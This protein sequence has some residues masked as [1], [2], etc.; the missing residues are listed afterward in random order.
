MNQKMLLLMLSLAFAAFPQQD[1]IME[2]TDTTEAKVVVPGPAAPAVVTS[3]ASRDQ[4]YSREELQTKLAGYARMHNAG[5]ALLGVGIPLT[6][7]GI[8]GLA[9]G[10]AMLSNG[11][12][13]SVALLIVGEVGIGFGPEMLIAG[14]VLNNIGG[15]KQREYEQRLQVGLGINGIS[16]TYLF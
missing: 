11:Q 2:K 1:T 5:R 14:A 15:K 4:E 9:G 8:V 6:C 16:L 7:A 12:P 3:N 10:I 13:S